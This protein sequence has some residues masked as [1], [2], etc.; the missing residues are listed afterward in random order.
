MHYSLLTFA[1]TALCLPVAN[2]NFD[3]YRVVFA[4]PFA[5]GGS[6]IIWQTFS[7]PPD[8]PTALGP[9]EAVYGYDDSSDVSKHT[10]FR[11]EGSGCAQQQPVGNIDVLEMHMQDNP[12]LHWSRSLMNPLILLLLLANTLAFSNLQRP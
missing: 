11:C 6:K 1:L 9:N 8:C 7:T 4:R 5:Q 10:G 2:A 3:V 12:K